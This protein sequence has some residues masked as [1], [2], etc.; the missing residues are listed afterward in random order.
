MK[1]DQTEMYN[2]IVNDIMAANPSL[3]LG[4]PNDCTSD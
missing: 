3:K 4:V 1:L 2:K